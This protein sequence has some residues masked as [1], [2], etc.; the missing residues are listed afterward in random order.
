MLD[1][2][3]NDSVIEIVTH[4]RIKKMDSKIGFG[5]SLF[6]RLPLKTE[7]YARGKRNYQSLWKRR[8]ECRRL[9]PC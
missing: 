6:V 1:I 2:A 3:I 9:I 7:R 8:F 4:D 5:H